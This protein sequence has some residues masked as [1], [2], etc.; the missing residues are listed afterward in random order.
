M[1]GTAGVL[2][3]A[4]V[5]AA[6]AAGAVPGRQPA[7]QRAVAGGP[8][9]DPDV[10]RSVP[11]PPDLA[12]WAGTSSPEPHLAEFRAVAAVRCV[13][14]VRGV[15]VVRA[16]QVGTNGI[17]GL[18]AAYQRRSEPAVTGGLCTLDLATLPGV[19][20]VDAAS[21]WLAPAIPHDSCRKPL[22][23]VRDAIGAVRWRDVRVQK[24]RR[25]V[26]QAAQEVGCEQRWKTL[27]ALN[28][29][30]GSRLSAGGPVF[31]VAPAR[32]LVC[33]YR[34]SLADPEVGAFQRSGHLQGLDAGRLLAALAGPG[35][36]GACPAARDFAVLSSADPR[37]PSSPV[38]VELGGCWRVLRAD[39]PGLGRADPTV[40]RPLL[41]GG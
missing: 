35:R 15:W 7:P 9:A 32:V 30:P 24:L 40:A 12:P 3:T 26:S 16:R 10:T 19:A 20:L 21:R 28:P 25:I 17:A 6:A 31:P 27:A 8:R 14:E 37:R 39:P 5:I 1:I 13:Q 22:P 23:E 33:H 2:A 34:T 4:V 36:A 11:C 41:L 29:P 38:Q 18:Q